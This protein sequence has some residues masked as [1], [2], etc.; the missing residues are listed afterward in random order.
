MATVMVVSWF[1]T[2]AHPPAFRPLKLSPLHP[3]FHSPPPPL[4]ER[5]RG[6]KRQSS[7]DWMPETAVFPARSSL[8]ASVRVLRSARILLS[9]SFAGITIGVNNSIILQIIPLRCLFPSILESPHCLPSTSRSIATAHSL[10]L[11]VQFALLYRQK[12]ATGYT[13]LPSIPETGDTLDILWTLALWE[14]AREDYLS[15]V[16]RSSISSHQRSGE[17]ITSLSPLLSSTAVDLLVH[18]SLVP[19]VSPSHLVRR[20]ARLPLLPLLLPPPS[21]PADHLHALPGLRCA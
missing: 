20:C 1:E 8:R 10:S 19:C 3:H 6:K 13:R 14:R 15:S 18:F 9:L 21:P 4:Q 11:C 17:S 12:V 5:N 2:T 16:I 7:D